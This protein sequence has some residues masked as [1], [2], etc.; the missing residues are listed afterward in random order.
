MVSEDSDE[1]VPGFTPVHRFS[2]PN[3]FY[4]TLSSQVSIVGHPL[5][6]RSEL[7][8]VETFSRPERILPKERD[9]PLQ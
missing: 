6:S 9:D 3:D 1:F 8:E 4:E 2:N 7:L 5:D